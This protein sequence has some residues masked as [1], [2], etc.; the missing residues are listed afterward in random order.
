MAWP[1]SARKV[2]NRFGVRFN[3]Q[4][5]TRISNDGLDIQTPAGSPVVAVF[6]GRVAYE[7]YLRGLGRFVILQHPGGYY[8]VYAHL[9]ES[10]VNQG[11]AVVAGQMVG[12]SGETG[13]L[14]GPMLHFEVRDG[15]K[16]LDPQAWLKRG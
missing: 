1:C 2:K 10:L 5:K 7:G 6:P 14:E 12:R 3:P 15:K 16:P 13:S 8:T 9:E 11:Q 4:T